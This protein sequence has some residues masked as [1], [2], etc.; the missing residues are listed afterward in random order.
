MELHQLHDQL[1]QAL[2]GPLPGQ[3]AADWQ[4]ELLR[5]QGEY[6]AVYEATWGKR[7]E[8]MEGAVAV[9]LVLKDE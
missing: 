5:L 8:G 6:Q 2:H 1:E 4:A 7:D 9:F 3:S